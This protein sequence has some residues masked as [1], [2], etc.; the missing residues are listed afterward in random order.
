M[1]PRMGRALREYAVRTEFGPARC[2]PGIPVPVGQRSSA[3]RH[4]GD[5]KHVCVCMAALLH[6]AWISASNVDSDGC[7]GPLPLQLCREPFV[8]HAASGGCTAGV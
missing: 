2:R 8:T 1:V 3:R 5:R 7:C 4:G 6:V